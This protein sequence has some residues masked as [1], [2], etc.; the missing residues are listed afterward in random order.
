MQIIKYPK[1][2]EW[3]QLIQRPALEKISL[4]KRVKKI[5]A[6]VRTGGDNAVK[7]MTKEFDR[8]KIKDLLVSEKEMKEALNQV[9]DELKEAIIIAKNNI[10]SFHALQLRQEDR[11]E[12]MPGVRCWRKAVGIEKVG[13]YIPGGT[14]PLFSTVLMLAI[15]AKLAGCKEIVLCTP[16]QKDGT[17]NRYFIY[18]STGGDYKNIQSWRCTGY[19]SYG[20]RY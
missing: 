16:P 11:I 18:S 1:R 3:K 14:A 15:P 12:T 2:E 8:V 13:L 19:S 20:L 4:E 17:I 5:L 10:T 9:P 6:K 7:K